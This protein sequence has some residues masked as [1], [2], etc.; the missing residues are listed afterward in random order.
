[1]FQKH[2]MMFPFTDPQY[3]PSLRSGCLN[4]AVRV[5]V[6]LHTVRLQN[7][8]ISACLTNVQTQFWTGTACCLRLKQTAIYQRLLRSKQRSKKKTCV[9][10]LHLG[11]YVKLFFRNSAQPVLMQLGQNILYFYDTPESVVEQYIDLIPCSSEWS[12]FS[13]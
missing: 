5:S 11:Y 13:A 10:A 8:G 1:M 9:S 6:S 12:C 7:A 2:C 3:Q 4:L